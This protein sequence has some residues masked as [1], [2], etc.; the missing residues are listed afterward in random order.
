MTT[1]Q[2]LDDI[3]TWY[4]YAQ[5]FLVRTRIFEDLILIDNWIV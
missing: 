2:Q 5:N 1:Q 3:L 4:L